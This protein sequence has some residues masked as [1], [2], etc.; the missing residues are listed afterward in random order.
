M[1]RFLIF[2]VCLIIPAFASISLAETP[3]ILWG[4]LES[5]RDHEFWMSERGPAAILAPPF[6]K[7]LPGLDALAVR[8]TRTTWL[9]RGPHHQLQYHEGHHLYLIARQGDRLLP[10][11]DFQVDGNNRVAMFTVRHPALFGRIEAAFLSGWGSNGLNVR[12]R[13]LHRRHDVLHAGVSLETDY[14]AGLEPPYA[15]VGLIRGTFDEEW[16][17]IR[18][19]ERPI[20]PITKFTVT[21]YYD[22]NGDLESVDGSVVFEQGQVLSKKSPRLPHDRLQKS[23]FTGPFTRITQAANRAFFERAVP[24]ETHAAATARRLN[25]VPKAVKAQPR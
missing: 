21:R 13:N 3:A 9:S 5:D 14:K 10:I 15:A 24:I 7:P 16:N 12:F 19:G 23:S 11:I 25:R 4:A 20:V 8:E 18:D 6:I 1:K 17:V 22:P 2:C